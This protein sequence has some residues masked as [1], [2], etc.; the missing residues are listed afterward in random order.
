MKSS[1]E[2]PVVGCYSHP[3]TTSDQLTNKL[4]FN[5]S[6]DFKTLFFIKLWAW[7]QRRGDLRLLFAAF[8]I[9]GAQQ[10]GTHEH[11]EFDH[12][13]ASNL[14]LYWFL[15]LVLSLGTKAG[16]SF[17]Q[18]KNWQKQLPFRKAE[19]HF[20]P[21]G[22]EVESQDLESPLRLDYSAVTSSFENLKYL[23]FLIAIGK[24]PIWVLLDRRSHSP[25]EVSK[26]REWM[27]NA[28]KRTNKPID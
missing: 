13:F 8:L 18:I 24:K 9:A 25:E 22:I 20:I 2:S 23:F 4:T 26:L 14:L 15:L 28:L 12:M 16:S 11:F 5:V 19:L 10:I 3:V 6:F 1:V 21:N 27:L 17:Y 7:R